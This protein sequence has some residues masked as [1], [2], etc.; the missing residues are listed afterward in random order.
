[1]KK[2]IIFYLLKVIEEEWDLCFWCEENVI[3]FK[4]Y[5]FRNLYGKLRQ[6]FVIFRCHN[7]HWFWDEFVWR[8]EGNLF[9]RS[10]KRKIRRTK[11]RENIFV[12][13]MVTV[14]CAIY[15]LNFIADCLEGL[16]LKINTEVWSLKLWYVFLNKVSIKWL[17]E[18]GLD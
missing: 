3:L 12:E 8:R 2:I 1:L 13:F 9:D 14:T 15:W 16:R 6:S 11:F 4:P 7:F 5:A 10:W 18:I 17:K